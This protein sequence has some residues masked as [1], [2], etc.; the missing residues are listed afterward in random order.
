[1]IESA[2]QRELAGIPV[3]RPSVE[4]QIGHA[5]LCSVPLSI[6][7]ITPDEVGPPL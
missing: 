6:S 5:L 1:M 7:I 2:R 3:E 4:T